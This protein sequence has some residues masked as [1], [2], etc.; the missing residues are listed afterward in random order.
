MKKTIIYYLFCF[1]GMYVSAL[2]SSSHPND[3]FWGDEHLIQHP[4]DGFYYGRMVSCA[5]QKLWLVMEKVNAQNIEYWKQ[6][7][8][9][10]SNGR[11]VARNS[12]ILGSDGKPIQKGSTGDG[13][14]HF[15][16]VLNETP[17][18]QNE[19]WIAYISHSKNVPQKIT[20]EDIKGYSPESLDY[21]SGSDFTKSIEMF[22]TITSSKHA[23]ITSHLGIAVSAENIAS[24][25]RRTSLD[26]HSF[27][28]KVMLIRNPERKYMITAPVFAMGNIIAKALP[29]HVYCGTREMRKR[30]QNVQGIGQNEYAYMMNSDETNTIRESL[31]KEVMLRANKAVA[32][33]NE[34]LEKDLLEQKEDQIKNIIEAYKSDPSVKCYGEID[35]HNKIVVSQEKIEL[36]VNR[37][38]QEAYQIFKNPYVFP[39]AE[40]GKEG[41]GLLK[42]MES[43]P[44]ILSVTRTN[45]KKEFS[46]FDPKNPRNVWLSIDEKNSNVYD[47]MFRPPF[48]PSGSAYYVVIDLNALANC[49]Q[50]IQ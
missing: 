7:I 40:K 22:V 33:D 29:D 43:H 44:P 26:L 34:M 15:K 47:W 39:L 25:Q 32:R 37:R 16:R 12:Q 24:R 14:R 42:Y 28:A 36:E 50:L 5:E 35:S 4:S 3:D 2:Q 45:D 13:S 49:K 6:Y 27:A 41:E 19:I 46:I 8:N 1:I 11:V 18:A 23:L 30:L 48:H 31:K 9:V 21:H 20:Y 10:Q 38:L 17:L